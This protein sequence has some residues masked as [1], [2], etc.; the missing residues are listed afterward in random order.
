MVYCSFV[1]YPRM[2]GHAHTE[3]QY[4][5]WVP[6]YADEQQE[7]LSERDHVVLRSPGIYTGA[8]LGE[9]PEDAK[10]YWVSQ[11]VLGYI[12]GQ[13]RRMKERWGRKALA[14]VLCIF[15]WKSLG[16]WPSCELSDSSAPGL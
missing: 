8:G 10:K 12:R 4:Q 2:S 3:L 15:R 6:I 14:L 7:V 1:V 5:H 13:M 9:T 16:G 11:E